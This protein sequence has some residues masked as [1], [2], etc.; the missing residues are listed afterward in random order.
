MTAYPNS[1]EARSG[2][3]ELR[4]SLVLSVPATDRMSR[5]TCTALAET[6]G[7]Q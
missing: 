3:S 4:T 5:R 1:A 2:E 7:G 6:S